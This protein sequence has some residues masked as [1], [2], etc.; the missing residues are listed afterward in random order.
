MLSLFLFTSVNEFPLDV[1]H[2]MY[3]IHFGGALFEPFQSD[4]CNSGNFSR[5]ILLI[6]SLVF[7][8]HRQVGKG[9]VASILGAS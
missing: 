9:L 2:D 5:V 6:S 7:S 4:S 8:V 1:F 3:L